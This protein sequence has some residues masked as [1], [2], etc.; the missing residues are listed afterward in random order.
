[1]DNRAVQGKLPNESLRGQWCLFLVYNNAESIAV[2]IQRHRLTAHLHCP[3]F[4]RSIKLNTNEFIV[5]SSVQHT[6]RM[7]LEEKQNVKFVSGKL[8]TCQNAINP[9]IR[10]RPWLAS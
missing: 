8:A 7:Q 3:S 4:N 2:D 9:L 6:S 1:M 5:A 10:R